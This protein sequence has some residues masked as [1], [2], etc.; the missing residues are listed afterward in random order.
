M[1]RPLALTALL[2][3]VA[4]AAALAATDQ[5]DAGFGKRGLVLTQFESRTGE[6]AAQAVVR[7]PDGKLVVVGSSVGRDG[8]QFALARYTAAGV[9]DRTFGSRGRVLQAV[10]SS[11]S[12]TA[13]ALQ[14]EKLIVAGPC[15]NQQGDGSFAVARFHP[16]GTLDTSFGQQGAAFT[17]F[18]STA[19]VPYDV[20]VGQDGKIVVAGITPAGSAFNWAVARYLENG[21]PDETFGEDGKVVVDFGGAEDYAYRVAVLEDG[22]VVVGG[23][24]FTA[25]SSHLAVARLKED[26]SLDETFD[27][28][29]CVALNVLQF[30]FG[31]GMLVQEDGKIVVASEGRRTQNTE[32]TADFVLVRLLTD[33]SLDPDFGTGG[34]VV[35]DLQGG[36]DIP[37]AVAE[38]PDGKLVVAGYRQTQS[39]ADFALA[40]YTPAG[41][42]DPTF[43]V[44]GVQLTNF[45]KR[46]RR[47]RSID[48]G[49]DVLVQPDGKAVAVG[50]SD[51]L[52][53]GRSRRRFALARYAP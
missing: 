51:A 3:S 17:S 43:G 46:N 28:D 1:Q 8:G 36:L 49:A 6:D 47:N 4:G 18:G 21:A 15:V 48:L 24:T 12:A 10:Q 9:L 52:M 16:D 33:G 39:D 41:E 35:T 50:A 5:L 32:I 53:G 30:D 19:D 34:K 42:L 29:G 2:I 7:Q 20:A 38:G 40:R 37:Y 23:A 14:G 27:G 25:K 11:A 22:R 26:G 45:G 44:Q 31:R 13:V